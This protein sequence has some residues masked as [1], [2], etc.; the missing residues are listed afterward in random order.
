MEIIFI[1]YFLQDYMIN[2]KGEVVDNEQLYDMH[3]F[4]NTIA[5]ILSTQMKETK[6][7]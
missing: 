7:M 2:M 6:L 5:S 3:Q 4:L 1:Y